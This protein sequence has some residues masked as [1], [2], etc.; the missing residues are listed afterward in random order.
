MIVRFRCPPE[1]EGLL[2]RPYPAKRGLPGWLK[3]MPMSVASDD[4][5]GEIRT[6]KHCP[7]FLDAMSAG[8]MIPLACDLTV[9]EGRFTW[10]WQPPVTRLG[11]VT[12]APIA[13]HLNDQ[14][15][16]SPL[17]EAD[18]AIV[19]FNNFWTIELAPG[20][21]LLAT[22]P[23][24]R[25]D[26]PFRTIAGLVDA[27]RYKDGLIQFPARWHQADFNGVLPKGTP[28]AQCLA[29]PREALDLE[30]GRIE[31]E[32]A[33]RFAATKEAVQSAPGA[34]RKRYR[35]KRA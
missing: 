6:V 35:A 8:F 18:R 27:D 23:F 12:R 32:A 3:D 10:D 21:A 29:L 16:D 1:L 2:P 5:G 30:F 25:E 7:P 33:E 14:A 19:K 24:N 4:A 28:V 31:G 20:Y 9:G 17:Y 15:K 11:G 26:L 34:Y 13:F 22:H